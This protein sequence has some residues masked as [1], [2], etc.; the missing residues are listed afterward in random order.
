MRFKFY[1]MP[2]KLLFLIL[3]FVCTAAYA[4]ED[5]LKKEILA[6]TGS[7]TML[8]RNA[9]MLLLDKF[10]QKD[11]NDVRRLKNFLNNDM[12]NENYIGL[13]EIEDI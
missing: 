7:Q 11:M 3:S 10:I 5:S 4:Q 1:P 12:D 13:Y 9:R 6:A 8:I 2:K